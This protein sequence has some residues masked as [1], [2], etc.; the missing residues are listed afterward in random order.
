MKL[1]NSGVE[2]EYTLKTA[3]KNFKKY[4][5]LFKGAKKMQKEISITINELTEQDLRNV[6]HQA[7]EELGVKAGEQIPSDM[8]NLREQVVDI[9]FRSGE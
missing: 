1:T 6:F 4:V 9:L 2:H 7:I 5:A 3:K 8:F